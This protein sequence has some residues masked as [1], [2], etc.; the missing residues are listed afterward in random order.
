MREQ[1]CV[2]EFYEEGDKLMRD[3]YY[4]MGWLCCEGERCSQEKLDAIH[5]PIQETEMM[6]PD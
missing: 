4:V 2:Y 3:L 1:R 6:M 5:Y